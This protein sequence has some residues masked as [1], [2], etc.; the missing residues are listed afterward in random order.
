MS[1]HPP[2]LAKLVSFCERF[3]DDGNEG[4][5]SIVG[6]EYVIDE[7]WTPLQGY[8]VLPP[9]GQTR[10][11]LCAACQPLIGGT[12]LTERHVHP[13]GHEEWCAG[14]TRTPLVISLV[15]LPR[16]NA[17]T[18]SI[19]SY[20]IASA[21]LK[22]NKRWAFV[23]AAKDQTDELIEQKI[24]RPLRRHE[25]LRDFY[26]PVG[27]KIEIPGKNSWIEVLPTSFGSV[28]GRGY[29]G[30][31][32]DESR[33]VEAR[34]AA[35]LMPSIFDCHGVECP[36]CGQHWQVPQKGSGGKQPP[37]LCPKCNVPPER[38]YGRLL[39]ASSSG[40]RD[41]NV[42]R[43]W[44]DDAVEKRLA[45]PH[46]N[47]HVFSTG[48]IL[49]P[50]VATEIVDAVAEAW[51]DVD[52]INVH[53]AVETTNQSIRRGEAFL[54]RADVDRATD[55]R[56]IDTDASSRL[57][58]WF[59]DASEKH[60][61]TTL[62]VIVD[63]ARANETPF[64]RLALQHLKVWDP[65]NRADCPDGVIDDEAIA[66]YLERVADR[67]PKIRRGEV[68]TRGLPWAAAMMERCRGKTWRLRA[69]HYVGKQVDDDAAYAALRDAVM[70]QR[71]RLPYHPKLVEELLA[72]QT[73]KRRGG[74]PGVVDPN[75]NAQGRNRNRGGLHRDVS[76]AVAGAVMLAHEER[77]KLDRPSDERV[78]AAN[79]NK[80]LAGRFQPVGSRIKNI[81]G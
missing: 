45:K 64:A 1:A 78:L 71:L 75:A 57:A 77:I 51:A 79:E 49:N 35:A 56:L 68:D 80:T 38:W 27:D 67:F 30:V 5:W 8:R 21:F 61:L 70:G 37:A 74:L 39:F 46:R 44:F 29:T 66:A 33:D 16:R 63:D 14:A 7:I 26:R 65:R 11:D 81:K 72:I 23:A 36:K 69:D 24:L 4:P 25:A 54:T 62:A 28:T 76:M 2:E 47:V 43:E 53:V 3:L 50:S 40:I 9:K 55:R 34:V 73:I 52:G 48:K 6:R 60:D 13:F 12:E 31:L 58:V 19:L 22:R 20:A 59:L 15:N 41:G 32:V 42:S 18:H 17:K 10:E